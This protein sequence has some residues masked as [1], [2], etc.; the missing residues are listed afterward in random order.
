V[1]RSLRLKRRAAN[2]IAN[3]KV[4][5]R[6]TEIP[7]PPPGVAAEVQEPGGSGAGARLGAVLA[8]TPWATERMRAAAAHRKVSVLPQSKAG[9]TPLTAATPPT[10]AL[11]DETDAPRT[12]P[13]ESQCMPVLGAI[14]TPIS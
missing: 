3:S 6:R 7:P 9:V 13:S 8:A 1:G 10:R 4:A 14:E 2:A 5:N 12:L 11:L